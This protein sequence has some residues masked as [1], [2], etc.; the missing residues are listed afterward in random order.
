MTDPLHDR[1]TRRGFLGRAAAGL[2]GLVGAA[3]AAPAGL[4]PQR[5]AATPGR[6][7]GEEAFWASVRDQFL[8]PEDRLYFNVGTLG[9]QPRPV[10]EAAVEAMRRTAMTYPPG[11]EWDDLKARLAEVVGGDP[12]GFAFPRNTTEAMNF[13]ANGLELGAGDEVVTTDH[14]HIGG[15]CCWELARDRRGVRLTTV[16]LPLEPQGPDELV[17]LFAR[18]LGPRTR[19]VSVSHVTFTN[20][21]VLPVAEIARLCHERGIVSVVDGAHPPG[22]MPVDVAAVGADFYASSPHKWLLAPQGTGFLYIAG[23]WRQRLWPTLASGGWDDPELGAHRFNHL[24]T[25]DESRLW[26]LDAALRFHLDIGTERV[27]D[28]VEFLRRR[29]LDGLATLP[30]VEVVTPEAP[31]LAAGMVS[32]RVREMDALVLQ[33]K[34]AEAANVRSRVIGEYGYG[35]MR[36]SP[37][38]YNTPAEVDRV[39]AG[40]AAE[41]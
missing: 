36:L 14:E 15:L 6:D 23:G 38:I 19:V 8:I 26:G 40:I 34:L 37:H 11:V 17:R 29:L 2:A 33:R 20:G 31:G 10:L 12:E 1:S 24:G 35:W 4:S 5:P 39:L 27:A 18:A 16:P 22:L 41:L 9:P 7:D 30:R 3:A 25:I 21:L 13:V 32:F 28:R